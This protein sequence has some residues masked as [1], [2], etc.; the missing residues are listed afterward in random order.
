[1]TAEQRE[2]RYSDE[3]QV[4]TKEDFSAQVSARSKTSFKFDDRSSTILN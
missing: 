1:M 4:P 2:R 3:I